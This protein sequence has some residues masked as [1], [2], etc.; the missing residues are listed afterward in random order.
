MSSPKNFIQGLLWIKTKEAEVIPFRF[1]EVQ[2]KVY[3]KIQYLRKLNK[4]IRAIILKARQTGISTLTEALIFY[5]TVMN[6]NTISLII[7]HDKESTQHLFRMSKMFYDR[8]P[9]MPEIKPMKRTSNKIELYFDNP[10][11]KQRHKNPGLNSF[12]RVDTAGNLQAGKS[13]TIQ[14]LHCSEVAYWE[15]QQEVMSG[16]LPSVPDLPN[17]MIIFESTANGVGDYFHNMWLDA[18][19]G[20]NDFTPIFI[21]WFELDSY[22][23][24]PPKDFEPYDYEHEIYGN[25]VKL[26]ETFELDIEQ[27]AWRRYTIKNKCNN[28]INMFK[29]YYPAT[30]NEAFLTSGRKV[31]DAGLIG[32]Y[33]QLIRA[34]K[35]E[36]KRGELVEQVVISDPEQRK[37]AD[38]E[39]P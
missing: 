12:I 6:A 31:F 10:S 39:R 20:N 33:M 38:L 4:P 8:L 26:S 19:A 1:N 22:R 23:L 28:D 7:A 2:Q 29:Q 5:F 3:E 24:T 27:L 13:F 11:E 21:A 15:K 9:E 36:P 37:L 34:N 30:A 25:E 16:L 32:E 35:I 14:Y 17:T 18:E